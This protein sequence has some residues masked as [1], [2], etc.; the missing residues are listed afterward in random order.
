MAKPGYAKLLMNRKMPP[1]KPSQPIFPGFAGISADWRQGV[2]MTDLATPNLP[3]RDFEVTESFF[4]VLGFSRTWRDAGWM[5]LQRGRMQLEFFLDPG[6]NPLT[7]SFGCCL[8]LDDLDQFYAACRAAGIPEG[9]VG[10]PRLQRPRREAWGGRVGALIDPDGT[11][12]RLI[13]N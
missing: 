11:L 9:N 5:I 7:S 3:A 4:A 12:L 6:V 13:E 10:H 8:R 2:N 1:D